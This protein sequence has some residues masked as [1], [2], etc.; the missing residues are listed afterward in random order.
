MKKVLQIALIFLAVTSIG[1]KAKEKQEEAVKQ[2]VTKD[3]SANKFEG[4]TK[5]TIVDKTGLDGCKFVIKVR[6]DK[7]FEPVNLD[8]KFMQDGLTVYFKYRLSRAASICMFGQ[9]IILSE[10]VMSTN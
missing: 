7:H 8:E 5:G 1:C 6:E 2:E 3:T 9:P 10:I 4:Y